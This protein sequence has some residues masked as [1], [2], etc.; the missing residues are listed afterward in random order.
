[1]RAALLLLL[2]GCSPPARHPP[3]IPAPPVLD[4]AAPLQHRRMFSLRGNVSPEALVRLYVDFACAGP[5]YL[6]T[7]GVALREGVEV[8]LII[9]VDNVFSAEAVSPEGGVS[10][11]SSPLTLRYVPTPAPGLPSVSVTPQSPSKET[12][13]TL[14]GAID[15]SARAQ[16]HDD[17]CGTPVLGELDAAAFFNTGFRVEAPVN[18]TRIVAVKAII[19]EQGSGC[20]QLRVT[21]DSLAPEF[22][23]RLA[24]P[25]PS[26]N[27][28][29]YVILSATDVAGA[30]VYDGPSCE[31]TPFSGALLPCC[32]S[33]IPF[34]QTTTTF[35]VLGTDVA[36]NASCAT[37]S[38]AWQYDAAVPEA[39]AIVLLPGAPPRA[40]VPVG[41]WYV[42]V[43]DNAD[44]TA[45]ASWADSPGAVAANGLY[46]SAVTT[47][48]A[49]AR[50]V[51]ADG[52]LD[53]CSN[54]VA[55]GP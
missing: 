26:S 52:G 22:T 24:S 20:V 12:T 39:Q 33:I 49:T 3:E 27:G 34:P 11:C 51:R 2:V 29:A 45:P 15:A 21:N 48:F 13:F 9:G 35:S 4:A 30:Q 5:V 40:E 25:T 16:L 8:E 10:A 46:L 23:V 44:C 28:S 47:G 50:G 17:H 53:P 14:R 19:D 38:K 7:S 37:G 36:G 32:P 31:G 54:A 43:F 18:G 41:P 55:L 42:E 1:M 6:R